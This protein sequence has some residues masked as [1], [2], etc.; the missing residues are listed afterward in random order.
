MKNLSKIL[1]LLLVLSGLYFVFS[2]Q[3]FIYAASQTSDSA[4]SETAEEEE[5]SQNDDST[6]LAVS[7]TS[8][9]VGHLYLYPSEEKKSKRRRTKK[10]VSC[11]LQKSFTGKPGF[12]IAL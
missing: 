7:G 5:A 10:S 8:V 2:Y 1:V 12:I 3:Q 4:S 11:L 9:L 6:V